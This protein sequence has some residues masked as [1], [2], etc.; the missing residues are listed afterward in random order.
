MITPALVALAA[1]A[2]LTSW[3]Q[4]RELRATRRAHRRT[5]R[6]LARTEEILAATRAALTAA[7]VERDGRE[8]SYY[9]ARG[10][11][12]RLRR[13]VAA[14][15]ERTA[16][17]VELWPEALARAEVACGVARSGRALSVP[18]HG[19]GPLPTWYVRDGRLCARWGVA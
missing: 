8:S 3:E 5:L 4:L 13:E 2:L 18:V 9:A 6:A 17:V 1:L 16:R 7:S 19:A 15:H 11:A 12:A 14:L 10:E